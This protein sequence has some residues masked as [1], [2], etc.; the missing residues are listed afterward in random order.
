[1]AKMTTFEGVTTPFFRGRLR[2]RSGWSP[3]WG[4][5]SALRPTP[6][7]RAPGRL[8]LG[9]PQVCLTMNALGV[10][11]R[12]EGPPQRGLQPKRG[13]RRPLKKRC[14]HSLEAVHFSHHASCGAV[15]AVETAFWCRAHSP[16]R[17]SRSRWGAMRPWGKVGFST[18]A[19]T[20]GP[21]LGKL[22]KRVYLCVHLRTFE[23]IAPPPGGAMFSNVRKCTHAPC[24][25]FKSL[26]PCHTLP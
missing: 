3:L 14:R 1:M 4:G 24:G 6:K 23:N 22:N 9:T 8:W 12:A 10:G 7:P 26:P 16:R 5:P 19:T 17:T 20:A 18:P 13:R 15:G 11:R 2:P 25:G 21:L